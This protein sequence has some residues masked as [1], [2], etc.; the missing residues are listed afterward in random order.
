MT[1]DVLLLIQTARHRYAIQRS[2]VLSIESIGP[3]GA[4]KHYDTRGH[5]Y[6]GFELGPLLDP[7]DRSTRSRQR[8]LL[9]SLRRRMVALLVEH[10]EMLEAASVVS[11][12]ALLM[13]RRQQPWA[14]AALVWDN[15]LVIQLDLRAVA[16]SALVQTAAA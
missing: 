3:E 4:S 15:D 11:L 10:V 13:E 16:R 8:A 5:P 6:M 9:V 7:Q 12:P 2:D 1:D 14:I